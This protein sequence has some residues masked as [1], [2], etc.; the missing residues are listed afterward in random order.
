MSIVAEAARA[1]RDVMTV[2]C[3][4]MSELRL[5]GQRGRRCALAALAVAL[6]CMAALAL[7]LDETWWAAIS[8]FMCSQATAPAS[9]QR[10][11]LRILGTAAGAGLAVLL[12]PLLA[13][14]TVALSLAL[15]VGTTLGVLGLLVSGH[16]YAWLL[17]A[18]TADMVFLALLSDPSSAL[19]VGANRTLEVVIGTTAAMA[20]ALLI[21]PAEDA[22][23]QGPA[24]G[25]SDLRGAQWPAV[26]HALRAGVGV[27]LVPLVWS[28]L[29]LPSLSQTA[30]TI[31]AVMAVPAL[32]SDAGANQRKITERALH[33][34]LGC[35]SG[36]I[37]G[38]A[39]LAVSI[40]SLLPWMLMLTT[41]IWI[42]AHIQASE[43]GIG[44]VGTQGGVV[45]IS[46]LVQG[47]GPAVS[48]LPG[49][50]RFVGI[51]GGLLILLAVLLLTAP[52]AHEQRSQLQAE[53]S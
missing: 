23:P 13:G 35:L 24:P 29:E 42:A 12:S 20:V 25:W 52:P 2:L 9:V 6:A 1:A 8:A 27:M 11:V 38:L 32:S 4:E 10:G 3:H 17:S 33:R 49:I 16:G 53:G 28:W 37:A 41:G 48:I 26:G 40:D 31:T 36:G 51:T 5:T 7:H 22:V 46:T 34:I 19:S 50:E 45:F 30:I 21:A 15:L 43:R 39:C 14:D 18:I 47:T 44:Y